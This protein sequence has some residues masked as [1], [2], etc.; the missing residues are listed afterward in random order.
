[1]FFGVDVRWTTV[2][3]ASMPAVVVVAAARRA[4]AQTLAAVRVDDPIGSM[5]EAVEEGRTDDRRAALK[6]QWH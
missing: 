6:K 4:K 2:F 1:L 3:V 5:A